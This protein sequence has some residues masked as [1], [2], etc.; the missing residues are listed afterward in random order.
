MGRLLV[1]LLLVCLLALPV[2]A[3]RSDSDQSRV[4]QLAHGPVTEKELLYYLYDATDEGAPPEGLL[5]LCVMPRSGADD[6]TLADYAA[7]LLNGNSASTTASD[8]EDVKRAAEIIRLRC[9]ALY[10]F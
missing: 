8:P 7:S 4:L 2:V 5:R 9:A 10:R 3:C 6:Q 1:E